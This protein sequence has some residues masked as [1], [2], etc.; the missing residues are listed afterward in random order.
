[1]TPKAITGILI[2]IAFATVTAH[3]ASAAG[4]GPK[5]GGYHRGS[6][7]FHG[8]GGRR[9][10]VYTNGII[11]DGFGYPGGYEDGDD[12]GYGDWY[13][14]SSGHNECPLFRQR[15]MTPDGWRFQMVPIC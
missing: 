6:G 13:G 3:S 15:M 10:D 2:L 9:R 12:T 4:E 1:M 8:R 7:G 14:I 5:A 11:V